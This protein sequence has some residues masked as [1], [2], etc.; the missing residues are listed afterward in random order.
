MPTPPDKGQEPIT[1]ITYSTELD[2]YKQQHTIVE[3]ERN[4]SMFLRKYV[5]TP[6]SDIKY[7]DIKMIGLSKDI[8]TD[9][10]NVIYNGVEYKVQYYV[11][12]PRWNV[13]Y[14]DLYEH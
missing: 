10:D 2:E 6:E 4:S 1:V 11:Y 5:Q 14:L 8:L 3:S 9:S 13:Y 7:N 12:T